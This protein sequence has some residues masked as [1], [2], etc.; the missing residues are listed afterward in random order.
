MN[1]LSNLLDRFGVS[2]LERSLGLRP[3]YPPVA[4]QVDRGSLS[5]VRLKPRRGGRS[6]LEASCV[7]P[8]EQSYVPASIFEAPP[9]PP[10]ELTPRLVQ[11][12]ERTGSRPG[13]M[14]VII[15]DNLAKITLLH[16][17]ERPASARQLEEL[18]RSQ[19]RRA[20]PFKLEDARV[21]YQLVPGEGQGVSVLVM[22]VRRSF[23]ELFEHAAEGAGA[24]IGLVD[25]CTTNLLNLCRH[26]I[27]K[28]GKSAGDVAL[29]N[30]DR[31][32]FS[33]AIVREGRLIFLR[34]KTFVLGPDSSG[35]PNGA[36]LREIANSLSYYREKLQGQGVD[37]VFV[38][39]VA[40]PVDQVREQIAT[41]GV[42]HLLTIDPNTVLDTEHGPR[43]EAGEAQQVAPAIGAAAGRGR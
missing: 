7:A 27:A 19:M 41:L 39:S 37:T 25:V 36:L 15:P 24:R 5:M 11:L 42:E 43:L 18:V 21:T 4:L 33:M 17:P 1:P 34:C 29:L 35:G 14:S 8:T 26:D 31:N 12:F 13:R 30:C 23:V 20:V 32:Y 22:L 38:R 6:A 28:A 2:D 9:V 3:H 16:L 40:Q 10:E